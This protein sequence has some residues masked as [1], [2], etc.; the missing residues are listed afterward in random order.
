MFFKSLNSDRAHLAR[1]LGSA[2]FG[3]LESSAWAR[4][5]FQKMKVSAPASKTNSLGSVSKLD[6]IYI[7]SYN[8]H[9]ILYT[10][11]YS[12]IYYN[13]SKV[14]QNLKSTGNTSG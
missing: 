2:R 10:L 9:N 11:C 12:D 14:S 3:W 8:L 5:F 6:I 13:D 4:F 1:G 7:Y